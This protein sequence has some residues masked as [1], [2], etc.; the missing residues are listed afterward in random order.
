MFTNFGVRMPDFISR[1]TIVDPPAPDPALDCSESLI[2]GM[3]GPG[4]PAVLP[5]LE[6][7]T[8]V[9]MPSMLS[10]LVRWIPNNPALD[11]FGHQKEWL[12]SCG[13]RV[14]WAPVNTQAS[15]EENAERTRRFIDGLDGPL[16]IMAHSKGGVDALHLLLSCPATSLQRFRFVL[17]LQSPFHGS[18]LAD[19]V[20]THARD[21]AGTMLTWFGGSPD[22]LTDLTTVTRQAYMEEHRKD[23]EALLQMVP[24][25]SVTSCL[26]HSDATAWNQASWRT[27]DAINGAPRDN[28]GIVA[29]DAAILPGAIWANLPGYGHGEPV[30]RV[31]MPNDGRRVRMLAAALKILGEQR[32][33]G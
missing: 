27:F 17:T 8:V 19:R 25:F 13:A 26:Q 6:G 33:A 15:V 28:D 23:I 31:F 30:Y 7:V 16:G 22:C 20:E 32:Q 21:M 11:Y 2:A 10:D 18:P 3:A 14:K 29:T 1:G 4:V 12:E 5:W 24:F 9:L